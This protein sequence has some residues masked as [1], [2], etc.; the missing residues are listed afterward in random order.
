MSGSANT[1]VKL[2]RDLLRLLASSPSEPRP[3]R[4]LRSRYQ[5]EALIRTLEVAGLLELVLPSSSASSRGI[6]RSFRDDGGWGWLISQAINEDQ[7]RS[8][9]TRPKGNGR[10]LKQSLHVRITDRGIQALTDNRFIDHPHLISSSV[11]VAQFGLSRRTLQRMIKDGRLTD[12]R[13]KRGRTTQL[14]LDKHELEIL[15]PKI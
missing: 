11:A 15:R 9:Q 5:D 2:Q 4:R 14:M 3:F 10:D 6:W 8:K 13:L 1:P 12:H 7:R